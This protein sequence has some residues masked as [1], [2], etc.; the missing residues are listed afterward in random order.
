M[1]PTLF[2]GQIER[3]EK[4]MADAGNSLKIKYGLRNNPTESQIKAWAQL[5]RESIR[6]GSLREEAGEAAAK[7]LFPD[8]RTHHYASQAD[9]IEALLRAAEG[10]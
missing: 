4:V 5:T 7:L 6:T 3:W 10:K 9:E 2:L 8:Y 1:N